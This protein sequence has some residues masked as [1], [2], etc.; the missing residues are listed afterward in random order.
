[1]RSEATQKPGFLKKP[2]FP[3]GCSAVALIA[4]CA[5]MQAAEPAARP[6]P[7]DRLQE[8]SASNRWQDARSQWATGTQLSAAA[9]QPAS[10]TPDIESVPMRPAVADPADV[11]G[12][13][14][15]D[16]PAPEAPSRNSART[17]PRVDPF[18]PPATEPVIPTVDPIA[19]SPA[20]QSDIARL[21][22]GPAQSR[23]AS[24]LLSALQAPPPQA[25]PSDAA[26]PEAPLDSPASEPGLQFPNSQGLDFRPVS[27]IAPFYDYSPDG[28]DPCQHLCPLP[29]GCPEDPNLL[30][31]DDGP[32]PVTG[33]TERYF[34][35][36]EFYWAA[37]N[38][39]HNPLYFENPILE[40]YGHVHYNDCVEPAFSMARFGV[41]F[42]SLPYQ[43]ALD[44]VWK[45]Q[46]ALGWYRP[47]DFAP[48]LIYQ[49]PLNARA[50]ATA[51][52]V[53]TGLFL[54]P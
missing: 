29:T 42:V 8:R 45:R 16:E 9:N 5:V 37:S 27:A 30:C 51:A 24:A 25:P 3:A 44:P 10:V 13:P 11:F 2:S 15:R 52:G 40:R 54:A 6:S 36:L 33:S 53:Y 21:T 43:I 38:L 7:L 26:P 18:A 47:G 46:F 35:H 32:I 39:H 14:S 50:A 20:D 48:K 1:M 31:P 23:T 17:Q 12:V 34:P 19:L 28:A 41:Q 49:P 4:C 22:A